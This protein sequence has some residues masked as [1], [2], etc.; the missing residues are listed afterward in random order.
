[1]RINGILCLAIYVSF[2]LKVRVMLV[3][4][5]IFKPSRYFCTDHSKA[6]F[7]RD[8]LCYLCF[9]LV[10]FLQPCGHL[11]GKGWPL[12]CDVSCVFVTYPYSDLGHVWYL[13]LWIPDLCKLP[14]FEFFNILIFSNLN[15]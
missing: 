3:L 5:N 6:V 2:H 9:V 7:F 15:R 13:I 14:Y 12:L 8:A 11:L 1:M 10:C 4:S